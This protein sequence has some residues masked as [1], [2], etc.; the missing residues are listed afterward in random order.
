MKFIAVEQHDGSAKGVQGP[1][2][3]L[4]PLHIRPDTSQLRPQGE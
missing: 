2:E 4:N 1:S 3:T